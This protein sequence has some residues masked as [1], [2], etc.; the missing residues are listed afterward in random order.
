MTTRFREPDYKPHH[1][2]CE[3]GDWYC[4]GLCG[5]VFMADGTPANW[6]RDC[7]WPARAER[8]CACEYVPDTYDPDEVFTTWRARW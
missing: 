3:D 2:A 7:N 6:C 1:P 5:R 4:C 8:D